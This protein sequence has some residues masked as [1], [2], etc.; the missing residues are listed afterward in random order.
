I[1]KKFV[2]DLDVSS[3]ILWYMSKVPLIVKVNEC[4]K[5]TVK[6][7]LQLFQKSRGRRKI[8]LIGN[9]TKRELNEW[10]IFENLEDLIKKDE[11]E[12][13]NRYIP[14]NFYVS[15]Q[16]RN[17]VSVKELLGIDKK[18]GEILEVEH[19]LKM[20]QEDLIIGEQ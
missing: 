14:Q 20:S 19:L 18:F 11:N 6:S 16:G 9:I 1:A 12:D 17:S 2:L 10:D 8:V 4:N 3:K 5:E 7:I 13:I 15:L